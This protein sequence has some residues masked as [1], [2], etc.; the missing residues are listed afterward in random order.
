M[1]TININFLVSG[2]I[3][4]WAEIPDNIP[5]EDFIKGLNEGKYLVS[6]TPGADVLDV[7]DS[8][9]HIG[10]VLELEEVD[11]QY[12]EYQEKI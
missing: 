9:Q 5:T 6:I 1:K 12:S 8:F 3:T 10:K 7:K 11:C 2:N 4:I